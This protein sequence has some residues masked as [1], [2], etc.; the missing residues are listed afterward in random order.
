MTAEYYDNCKEMANRIGAMRKK[1]VEVLKDVGSTHD[2]SH[3]TE[4]IGMFAYTGTLTWL[5]GF[6]IIWRFCLFAHF[7]LFCY[8]K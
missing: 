6:C 4:Q 3:V 2:W 8:L 1:L 5:M 7:V